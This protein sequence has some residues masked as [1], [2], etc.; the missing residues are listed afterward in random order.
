MSVPG[1]KLN[2]LIVAHDAG[3]SEVISSWVQNQSE[4]RYSFLLEGPAI[5][6]FK[7]KVQF[8]KNLNR[9]EALTQLGRKEFDFVLTGSSWAS[10]LE[11]VFLTHSKRLQIRCGT[12]L[13]HW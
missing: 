9:E 11:R 2:T 4:G 5:E 6:I 7:R 8:D 12:F 10:D 3:G 13:D 1:K